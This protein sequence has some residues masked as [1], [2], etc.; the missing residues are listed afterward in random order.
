MMA[1][2]YLIGVFIDSSKAD[3]TLTSPFS[4]CQSRYEL[5]FRISASSKIGSRI[6]LNVI[7][8]ETPY[9]SGLGDDPP[10]RS[11]SKSVCLC[12]CSATL[13]LRLVV[14]TTRSLVDPEACLSSFSN[15]PRAK[16][17]T[18]FSMALRVW[19]IIAAVAAIAVSLAS[20]DAAIAA[21]FTIT[22]LHDPT[23]TKYGQGTY[24]AFGT[25]LGQTKGNPGGIRVKKLSAKSLTS[26][27][28][29][30]DAGTVSVPSWVKTQYPAATNVWAPEI[31]M[32]SNT[33]YL[34]YAVSGFG[35]QISAIGVA[36]SKTPCVANSWVDHGKIITSKAGSTYNAID[37]NVFRD[38]KGQLWLT[39]GSFFGGIGQVKMSSPTTPVS[40]TETVYNVARRGS[41]DAVEGATVFAHGDFYY[42]F[43]SWDSCCKGTA[44]TY[45]TR[46]G[47]SSSPNGPF[48]DENGV[49]LSSGGGTS[50][51]AA[52]GNIIGPGGGDV[53]VDTVGSFTTWYY[54]FHYYDGAN[55]GAVKTAL[56]AIAWTSGKW[57][58]STLT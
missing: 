34:Y 28:A 24:C 20:V 49:R 50:F 48:V 36:S 26:G 35:T 10:L 12:D 7:C 41:P 5:P 31:F 37:P 33:Y 22:D 39:F 15:F 9:K 47:R 6:V 19:S 21:P 16:H 8:L 18:L 14:F 25:G 23:I 13:H 52:K 51:L 38:N 53:F 44:S 2:E 42:I 29:W 56:Q 55:N 30:T 32:E 43:T 1:M 4:G 40:S 58:R 46:V 27:G 54:I 3:G 17:K 45:K 57:P 11:F